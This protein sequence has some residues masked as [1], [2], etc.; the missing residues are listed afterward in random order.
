MYGM[1]LHCL[2]VLDLSI[3]YNTKRNLVHLF[4]V[5]GLSDPCFQTIHHVIWF[6][7]LNLSGVLVITT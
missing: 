1:V 7:T 4:G 5:A 2:N 3:S 6:T